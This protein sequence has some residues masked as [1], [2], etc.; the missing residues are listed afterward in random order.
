M[1]ISHS[2]IKFSRLYIK[3]IEHLLLKKVKIAIMEYL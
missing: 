2:R 1:L 3:G